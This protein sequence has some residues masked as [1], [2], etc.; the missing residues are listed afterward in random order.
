MEK[1][2]AGLVILVVIVA[3][4]RFAVRAV[5]DSYRCDDD[6][7]DGYSGVVRD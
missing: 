6:D 1:A 4:A 5:Y 7:E 3:A 2:L